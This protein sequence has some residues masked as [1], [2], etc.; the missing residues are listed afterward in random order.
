MKVHLNIN[1]IF[2]HKTLIKKP[3]RT[4]LKSE[5]IS[6]ARKGGFNVA[7]S[8]NIQPRDHISLFLS[9]GISFQTYGLA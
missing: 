1:L 3:L 5:F 4:F 8:Y 9:Y 6:Y 7:I 2:F